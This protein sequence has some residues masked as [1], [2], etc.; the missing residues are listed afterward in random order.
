MEQTYNERPSYTTIHKGTNM[1]LNT[2]KPFKY[3]YNYLSLTVWL[4]SLLYSGKLEE[5]N[6]H[7]FRG[8][9]AICQSFIR[10]I[11][12]RGVLWHGKNEQS[13]KVFSM[14]IVFFTN[15]HKFSPSSVS[16]YTVR[17]F[18]MQWVSPHVMMC[19]GSCKHILSSPKMEFVD[20]VTRLELMKKAD[21]L[22]V[23]AKN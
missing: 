17:N 3:D 2:R 5:E 10:E 13:V 19:V 11:W 16:C 6:F 12:G 4:K 20:G 15:S 18:W 14:K 8:F 1:R 22:K 9:M 23:V 7:K 21:E